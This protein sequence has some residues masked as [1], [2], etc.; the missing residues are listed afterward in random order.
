MVLGGGASRAVTKMERKLMNDLFG[1]A[2][3]FNEIAAIIPG[4]HKLVDGFSLG[5]Q[6][7][8]ELYGNYKSTTGGWAQSHFK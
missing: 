4:G 6:N 7:N 5:I 2:M 3:T 1:S 8:G